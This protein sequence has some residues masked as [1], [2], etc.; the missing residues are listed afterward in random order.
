MASAHLDPTGGAAYQAAVDAIS[1]IGRRAPGAGAAALAALLFG[2]GALPARAEREPLPIPRFVSMRVGDVNLHVGP[3][4]QYPV[5]WVFLKKNLPVEVVQEFDTWLKIRDSEGAE[6]WVMGPS[7]QGKRTVLVVG[8]IR[9]LREE[10]ADGAAPVARLE[11]GVIGTL[12][13]CPAGLGWCRILV[14][15]LRGWIRR[16]EIWGV[17]P[18]EVYPLP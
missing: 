9:T 15:N 4:R 17:T 16:S 3:G 6:G 12:D 14:E 18:D 8:E 11:P 1:V 13:K 2:L 5:A 7:L 10:G